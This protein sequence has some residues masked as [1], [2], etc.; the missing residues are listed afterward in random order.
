MRLKLVLT[1]ESLH[2]RRK[3][4]K[5]TSRSQQLQADY[6]LLYRTILGIA[7]EDNEQSHKISVLAPRQSISR[8]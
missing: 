3:S 5:E 7:D 1:D 6:D 8:T 2:T 4:V